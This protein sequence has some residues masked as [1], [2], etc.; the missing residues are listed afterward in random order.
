[1]ST[2]V[3]TGRSR[4]HA[5]S[6]PATRATAGRSQLTS[7]VSASTGATAKAAASQ[8]RRGT[9]VARNHVD[10]SARSANPKALMTTK[11]R[12]SRWTCGSPK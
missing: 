9:A 1:M 2:P 7:A 8:G 12:I 11:E 10:S 4:D 3:S 6:A 5:H